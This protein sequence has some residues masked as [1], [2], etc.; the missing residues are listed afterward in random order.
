MLNN[1]I[2]CSPK[3]GGDTSCYD[4]HP[5]SFFPSKLVLLSLSASVQ[6]VSLCVSKYASPSPVEPP[7]LHMYNYKISVEDVEQMLAFQFYKWQGTTEGMQGEIWGGV[8][9]VSGA[10][11]QPAALNSLPLKSKERSAVKTPPALLVKRNFSFRNVISPLLLLPP[12]SLPHLKVTGSKTSHG[13][14]KLGQS[15]TERRRSSSSLLQFDDV[16]N[17]T[18]E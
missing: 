2:T 13:R 1:N 8:Q 16:H 10:E 3:R 17:E 14:R 15:Q 11:S 18:K 9:T 6:D 4:T 7:Y 5:F 12:P